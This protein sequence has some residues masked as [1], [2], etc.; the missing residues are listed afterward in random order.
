MHAKWRTQRAAQKSTLPAATV[1]SALK[2]TSRFPW[3]QRAAAGAHRRDADEV[4]DR[5]ASA[6]HGD[7]FE[8]RGR[9]PAGQHKLNH[10][11]M[12]TIVATRSAALQVLIEA[13]SQVSVWGQDDL[14]FLLWQSQNTGNAQN[15]PRDAPGGCHVE[16]GFASTLHIVSLLVHEYRHHQSAVSA[17]CC[18]RQP[19][20][21]CLVIWLELC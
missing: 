17:G 4:L 8:D 14:I 5:L 19:G 18:Q 1:L 3:M 9:P 2:Q 7:H 6:L 20:L 12:I 13:Q 21:G 15:C 11:R 16:G 10:S